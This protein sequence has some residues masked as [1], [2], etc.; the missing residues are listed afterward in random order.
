VNG[1][2]GALSPYAGTVRHAGIDGV[3]WRPDAD[4]IV[5]GDTPIETLNAR[6]EHSVLNAV[7]ETIPDSSALDLINVVFALLE[8]LELVL[9]K[10]EYEKFLRELADRWE[11]LT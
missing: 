2:S 8:Q 5:I 3:E 1:V 11:S 10:N 9:G 6:M 7:L 4:R